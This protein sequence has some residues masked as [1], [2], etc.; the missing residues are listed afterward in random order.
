MSSLNPF[1]D[2]QKPQH[3]RPQYINDVKYSVTLRGYGPTITALV[4]L[5]NQYAGLARIRLTSIWVPPGVATS[6]Y[7]VRVHW[8]SGAPYTTDVWDQNL[9]S[10]PQ[11]VGAAL[12]LSNIAND[13]F[14]TGISVTR[15][16]PVGPHAVRIEFWDNAT[17]AVATFSSTAVIANYVAV[18][19]EVTPL[20]NKNDTN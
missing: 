16:L 3:N 1:Y 6:Y 8:G 19:L 18:Q 14:G 20:A 4:N 10:T 7:E 5:P 9:T 2:P 17:G 13:N 11:I 15:Y 12:T